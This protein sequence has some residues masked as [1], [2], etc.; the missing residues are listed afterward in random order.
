MLPAFLAVTQATLQSSKISLI[1][2]PILRPTSV[3][4][5]AP[6]TQTAWSAPTTA[7]HLASLPSF[8]LLLPA[9]TPSVLVGTSTFLT[10]VPP[11]PASA[12][13]ALFWQI[14]ALLAHQHTCSTTIAAPVRPDA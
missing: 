3:Y 7:V 8:F 13:P 5:V 14:T 10:Y 9:V 11:A 6:F 12:P 1:S 4:P 2:P